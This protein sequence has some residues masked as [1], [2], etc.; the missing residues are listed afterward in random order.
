MAIRFRSR[1]FQ[2]WSRRQFVDRAVAAMERGTDV[3]QAFWQRV[4]ETLQRL[5]EEDRRLRHLLG[6]A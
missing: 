3:P 4:R 5:T 1:E 2:R 6:E